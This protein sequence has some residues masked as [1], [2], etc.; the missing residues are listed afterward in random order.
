[1]S[2]KSPSENQ[3]ISQAEITELN[4]YLNDLL[5]EI[6]TKTTQML[7]TSSALNK[8]THDCDENKL[9]ISSSTI[10]YTSSPD[11]DNID[12]TNVAAYQELDM[13]N[14]PVLSIEG[15]SF[16]FNVNEEVSS[17][18]FDSFN[19]DITLFSPICQNESPV[20]PVCSKAD[21]VCCPKSTG[22]LETISTIN[23]ICRPPMETNQSQEIAYTKLENSPFHLFNMSD[24]DATTTEYT[25]L[26]TRLVAYYGDYAYAYSNTEHKPRKFEQNSYLMHIISYIK[27]VLP[28]LKFNSVMIHKYVN[29][30]SSMPN[31]SDDESCIENG[32]DIVSISLGDS[33]CMEFVHKDNGESIQVQLDH[34]DVLSMTRSS[35]NIFN[36]AIL[37]E[38]GKESRI[39]I[40]L[41]LIKPPCN[42]SQCDS[43]VP[44]NSANTSPEGFQ[45]AGNNILPS[46]I[47][48]SPVEH[49]TTVGYQDIPQNLGPD[50]I[51][52]ANL[53]TDSHRAE[54]SPYHWHREGWQPPRS[55]P[56][57]PPQ[58][59]PNSTGPPRQLEENQTG[60]FFPPGQLHPSRRQAHTSSSDFQPFY[61]KQKQDVVFISSSMFASLDPDKLS[62]NDV[63][64]HV[65]FYRGADSYQ[66]MDRLRR[67]VKVQDLA[68]QKS[69]TKVFLMTGTNNVDNICNNT[70]SLRDACSSISQTISYVQTLFC[71]ATVNVMNILPRVYENRKK[72]IGQ[73]NSHIKHLVV[74]DKSEKINHV[75]TYTFRMFT[76]YDGTRKSDLFR[77]THFND[78]D[79]VH[80]NT[81]GVI[82]LGRHLKYLAH[83]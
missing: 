79:N 46:F 12:I 29:G 6:D 70:Q 1:M 19:S 61:Q 32:S 11:A 7:N 31:H 65:F 35:Q 20:S 9:S 17:T 26:G 53:Q 76:S 21:D 69:V 60:I 77:K 51:R 14:D 41:R 37:S 71:T 5:K 54:E 42:E 82:K 43:T 62:S 56:P 39:S 36:H 74:K 50:P 25:K 47:T 23:T 13:I 22:S 48:N 10:Q 24:L 30:Q 63:N 38:S 83:S 45:D 59:R 40:T 78:N 66:M 27:I 4:K 67:D 33:R 18:E 55:Y 73:L 16:C 64:A 44:V 68:N 72:V 15:K 52:R 2:T 8:L 34:G 49:L 3:S 57:R 81:P 28:K 75:D 80:L 58:L